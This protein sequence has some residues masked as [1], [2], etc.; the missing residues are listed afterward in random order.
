MKYVVIGGT[1]SPAFEL[2]LEG[3]LPVTLEKY[4]DNIKRAARL[5]LPRIEKNKAGR[6]PLAVVGGGPSINEHVETL[7]NWSGDVLAINGAYGWCAERGIDAILFAIDPDPIVLR[8]AKGAKRAIL[9]DT[10]D[11]QVFD[12]LKD[13]EVRIASIGDGGIKGTT[14]AASCTPYL[15]AWM[16]YG[17]VTLFGCE[18]S[19]L[20]KGT[21][22]YQ[23]EKRQDHILVHCDGQDW[24]T[25]SDFYR[26]ATEIAPLVKGLRPWLSE[27][28]GGLLRAMI[29]DDEHRITWICEEFAKGLQ[30]VKKAA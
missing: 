28:S 5:E 8:W 15:G 6:R 16:G 21:H 19:Y 23:D 10:C 2:S 29:N 20:L 11:P 17:G 12:L 13:A 24:L 4:E 7:R 25:S 9:G 1:L 3:Q 18:S 27:E 26:Q 14:T 30:P 22:A